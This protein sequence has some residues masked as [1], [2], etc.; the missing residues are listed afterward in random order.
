MNMNTSLVLIRVGGVKFAANVLLWTSAEIC[1]KA[2]F[3]I[4]GQSLFQISVIRVHQW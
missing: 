1:G 4:R 3:F 2:L